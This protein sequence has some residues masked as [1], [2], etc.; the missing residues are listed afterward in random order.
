MARASVRADATPASSHRSP[1]REIAI[2]VAVLAAAVA[3]T[4]GHTLDAPFE[5]DDA[6]SIVENEWIRPGHS[7]GDL[8]RF[9]PLR[10]LGY[11]SFALNYRFGATDPRGYH[12][13]NIVIHFLAACACWALARLV[14]RTPR[15]RDQVPAGA[16]RG[17]A[18]L[19]GLL[20]ALHP[21]QTSA[22]TYVVQRLASMAALFFVTSLACFVQARLARTPAS[23]VA[24]I[25]GCAVAGT[26]ALLTKESTVT[27]P[28]ALALIECVMFRHRGRGRIAVALAALAGTAAVWLGIALVF[29]RNPFAP[30]TVQALTS[31]AALVTRGQYLATQL[32]ILWSYAR[33]FVWPAGLH[34]DHSDAHLD[35]F[36]HPVVWFAIAGH[37]LMLALALGSARHRPVLGFGLL[38]WYL[39]HSVESSVFPLQDMMFEH[40]AYLP[41]LGL[42]LAASWLLAV[43]LPRLLRSPRRAWEVT[44]AL[45][46][47]LGI[48][49]WRRNQMWRDP[50]LLWQDNVRHAPDRARAWG[51]LARH[52]T[53]AQRP[54]EAV[55]ALERSVRIGTA[56]GGAAGIDPLDVVNLSIALQ[57]LGKYEDAERLVTEHLGRPVSPYA[58]S[59]LWIQRGNL[60][61]QAGRLSAADSAFRAAL[62][63]DSSSVPAR[64]N[65]AS[66]WARSGRLG[67]AE[68]LFAVVAAIDPRDPQA[69]INLLQARAARL[70]DEAQR[71]DRAG[72]GL[73]ARR[74]YRSALEALEELAG[75]EPGNP[76]AASN[77]AG[78]REA[79]NDLDSRVLRR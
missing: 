50:I 61:F 64:A 29:G 21:L 52:L 11:F 30:G 24:A 56:R 18:L 62:A 39:A 49:T 53:D 33:L 41:D 44:A 38:F 71:S 10:V 31:D 19:A 72:H 6:S 20:F 26:L 65:L 79:I 55:A 63:Q 22:V 45:L 75:L 60:D 58:Q 46:I 47:V 42:C 3:L 32:P 5:L 78:V 59:L 68:S 73:D 35:G 69:R 14:V 74:S 51:S 67:A 27:L 12:V 9:A 36:G 17:L 76:A 57:S 1:W 37:L 28:L 23:R 15:V 13:V 54:A 70:I 40:R 8:W 7:F 43:E 2:G 77:I 48:V 66:T 16:G 34:L 4:Y 25:A